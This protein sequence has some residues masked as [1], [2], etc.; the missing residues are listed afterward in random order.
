MIDV[1]PDPQGFVENVEPVRCIREEVAQ[2]G[3]PDEQG[4]GGHIGEPG[5]G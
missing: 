4:G 2:R 3:L 5:R 1:F